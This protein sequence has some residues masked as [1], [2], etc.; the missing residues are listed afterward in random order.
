MKD[1]TSSE[2][3]DSAGSAPPSPTQSVK[4][5]KKAPPMEVDER[6]ALLEEGVNMFH[7]Y[8]TSTRSICLPASFRWAIAVEARHCLTGCT[9]CDDLNHAKMCTR[10]GAHK[11]VKSANHTSS[12]DLPY[13]VTDRNSWERVRNMVH[14]TIN[15]QARADKEWYHGA[16]KSLGHT[17]LVN[18]KKYPEGT[19][20]RN[21]L[22]TT[23][24][25][26][27]LATILASHAIHTLYVVSGR[28]CPSLPEFN[29]NFDKLLPCTYQDVVSSGL[30]KKGKG[31]TY[32]KFNHVPMVLYKNVDSK[33]A[34]FQLYPK[35][36]RDY[37]KVNLQVTHP[38]IS[39][40]MAPQAMAFCGILLEERFGMPGNDIATAWKSLDK[41]RFCTQD[42]FTRADW[43]V[44]QA[45][46]T[47]SYGTAC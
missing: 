10:G 35:I 19:E 46:I 20:Q 17:N 16:I 44:V 8:L 22:V 33:S 13:E 38:L 24:F 5:S 14:A 43:T 15:H 21:V 23:L 29:K 12:K 34:T 26:E 4:N 41:T 39:L 47:E 25:S 36:V 30:L 3:A 11:L 6:W 37:L 2:T 18:K 45:V 9:G 1:D 28:P 31:V 7:D 32:D 27:I 42:G 40:S